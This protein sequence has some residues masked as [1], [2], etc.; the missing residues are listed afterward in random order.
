MIIRVQRK[1]VQTLDHGA[2]TGDRLIAQPGQGLGQVPVPV[3]LAESRNAL[4]ICERSHGRKS[5]HAG[6]SGRRRRAVEAC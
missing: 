6:R 5:P 1:L 2:V 4:V 3:H